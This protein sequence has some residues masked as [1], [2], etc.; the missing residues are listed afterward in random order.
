MCSFQP[1]H[2]Q[3]YAYFAESKQL[4][5][6]WIIKAFMAAELFNK[7]IQL[8]GSVQCATHS[9][10]MYECNAIIIAVKRGMVADA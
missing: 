3:Y 1:F 9:L 4:E 10:L 2:L 8:Q 6:A 5:P 7:T